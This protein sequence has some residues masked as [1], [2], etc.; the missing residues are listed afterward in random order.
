MSSDSHELLE[1]LA[2]FTIPG[3]CIAFRDV[4]QLAAYLRGIDALS[5]D[6][7]GGSRSGQPVL[8]VRFGTGSRRISIV[9]GSHSDEPIGPM[10]AQAL[11]I[12]FAEA[13][14]QLLER[15]TFHVVPNINPDGADRNRTWFTNPPVF[16]DY[17]R[18]MFREPP[19]DD[20]EFGFGESGSTRPECRAA[21]SF[22]RAHGPYDAHFSLH[23]MP[24]AEGAWFL[25]CKEWSTR[26]PDLL[27]GL[28]TLCER[29]SVPLHDIDRHGEKGFT[30]IEAGFCTTPH[31]AGM[32]EHFLGLRDPETAAKFLPSSME[33]VQSLG[34]G[35]LCMV[36]EMPLFLIGVPGPSLTDTG[37]T[38]FRDALAIY[39]AEHPDWDETAMDELLARFA[40][41]PFPIDMQI[42]LQV[43]MIVL[44][45]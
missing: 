30:R 38:R 44:A 16:R 45:L 42:R 7:I 39:Q 36:S 34:S 26:A 8:G 24:F 11:P 1:R 14:P 35:P 12:L 41:T 15:F 3:D 2:T 10:T 21:M 23:G 22:L 25:L 37:F 31:S 13:F 43:A 19:G 4:D 5:V 33:F 9:A 27:N 29:L 18:H 28:T 6:R 40:V 20:I 17:V 32:R